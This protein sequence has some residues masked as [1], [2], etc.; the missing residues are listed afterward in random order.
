MSKKLRK[1][2]IFLIVM[3]ALYVAVF[4]CCKVFSFAW[5]IRLSAFAIVYIPV[6]AKVLLGALKKIIHGE[7]LDEDFLMAI[8]SIGAFVIGEYSEAVS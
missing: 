5:Y 3:L 2:L 7:F 4:V 6:G 1:E 8:A